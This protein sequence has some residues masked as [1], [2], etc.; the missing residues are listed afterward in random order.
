MLSM[1]GNLSGMW[2]VYR[3]TRPE[4]TAKLEDAFNNFNVLKK[5][6]AVRFGG[7]AFSCAGGEG[8]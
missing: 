3:G 4:S 7:T 6:K 5:E 8:S 1:Y 2:V